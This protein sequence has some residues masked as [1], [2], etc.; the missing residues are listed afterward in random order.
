MNV[1]ELREQLEQLAGPQAEAPTDARAAVRRRVARHR[2]RAGVTS[3]VAALLVVGIVGVGVRAIEDPPVRVSTAPSTA[4]PRRDVPCLTGV[5]TVPA[6]DVPADV[7]RWADDAAVVGGGELWTV[8][9]LLSL[10][11]TFQSGVWHAKIGW[12]TK[13]F[14]VP[15]FSGRRLDGPGT[16]HGDGTAATNAS[17][18]WVASGLDFSAEGCWEVTASYDT[19]QITFRLLVGDPPRPLAIGTVSGTLRLGGGLSAREDA[20]PGTV[21]FMRA[22]GSD[23]SAV[24]T[25][26]GTF[27]IDV[28]VGTYAVTATSPNYQHGGATCRADKPVVVTRGRT[29]RVHVKCLTR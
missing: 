17:G 5:K 9:S 25:S 19:S 11:P 13:P 4:A 18:T 22:D 12:F 3:L 20:I 10:E 28:P 14:G 8:R 7:A 26:D 24:A 15:R 29:S 16:F 6:K 23:V 1:E 2:R 27:S 21:T